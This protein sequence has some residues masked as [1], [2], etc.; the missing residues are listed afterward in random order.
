MT[1]DEPM[2]TFE[3]IRAALSPE[4][5]EELDAAL[6]HQARSQVF[7]PTPKQSLVIESE[8]DIVGYGGAAGGG[9]SYLVAGLAATRHKRSSITRPQKNQCQKF[10]DELAKMLGTREGYSSS[11]SSFAFNAE[12]GDRFVKFFGLDNPGDEEK[13]QGDDYDLKAYDEVTQMRE[14]DIRYTLTWL[15]T[16]DPNQRCQA[17][18]T[19]NPPT[20]AEGRWVIKFFAPWLDPQHPNPAKE[21]ELRWFAT[22]GDNQDYEVAG[23]QPFVIKRNGEGK[24]VPWYSFRPEDHEPEEIIKPKSRTFIKA[25]VVDNPYYMKSG[26]LAQLQGLPEPLRSQMLNGDFMAGVED[27]ANQLIPTAWI[28]LAM[29]RGARLLADPNYRIGPQDSIGVDVARGGN[30]GSQLGAVGHDEMIIAKRYGRLI[31]PLV[32]HRGVAIDDGAK[33]AA[34]TIAERRDDA[35]V[36]VDVI[37]VGTSTYDFLR[38]QNIHALPINGSAKSLGQDGILRFVNLRSELHWQMRQ[39]LDP[40]N[41]EALA[42]PPDPK[43]AVDLAAPRYSMTTS[44]IKVESKD[45]IKKRLGRSPDRGD[46]VILANISTAKRKMIIGG[47]QTP[48]LELLRQ[49]GMSYEERRMKELE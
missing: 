34:L 42:L 23:P 33:S 25:R 17:V 47:Y 9:K 2:L 6:R 39:A 30:M 12:G 18:L 14:A 43:L 36:H 31:A 13:Q 41:P 3:E 37:G 19:F 11:T 8:A 35:P 20:T 38:A 7:F 49:A 26:Y 40:M 5:R 29:E 45:D 28:D 27:D 15:R 46:A 24:L 44:G 22:V 1:L 16:D 4:E 32:A 10:V 21:G 48:E